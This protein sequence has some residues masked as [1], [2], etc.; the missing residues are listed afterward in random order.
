MFRLQSFVFP[1]LAIK[2]SEALYVRATPGTVPMLAD[3]KLRFTPGSAA[4]FDTFF[5]A[6]TV[7][8]WKTKCKIDELHFR[9]RGK[10]R[11]A[12]RFG[13][14]RRGFSQR[15]LADSEVSLVDGVDIRIELPF[16]AELEDGLLYVS[17]T[18]FEAGEIC[19]AAFATD[20][21]PV[22][23]VKLGIVITHFD[24]KQWVLPA[25]ERIR[26]NL[27]ADERYRGRIELVV[28]DNSRNIDPADAKGVTLIP[29][30]NL[31]GSGGF[32]RGLMHLEDEGSFTHCLFMDDD[33]SCEIESIRRAYALLSYAVEPKFAVAGS[34]LRAL[35]SHRLLEKG[36]RFD[37]IFQPL[38]SGLDMRR[39]DDLLLAER[40]DSHPSYGAWWFF[41]FSLTDVRHYPFPYFVRGDDITFGLM[42]KFSICTMNGIAT[43]SEDFGLKSGPLSLYLDVRSNIM[44]RMAIRD[45]GLPAIKTTAFNHFFYAQLRCYNYA[46]AAAISLAVEHI[47]QGPQFWRDNIDMGLVRAAIAAI[48]SEEKMTPI[49]RAD[50]AITYPRKRKWRWH[51]KLIRTFSLNGFLLP[52]RLIK[53]RM[54]FQRKSFQGNYREIFR[55]RKVLYEY[56]PLGLG[57][58][59]TYDKARFF[60]ELYV[61]FRRFLRLA[62]NYRDLQ[63]SYKKALPELTSRKFWEGVY[64]HEREVDIA[65]RQRRRSEGALSH[66]DGSLHDAGAPYNQPHAQQT[67][68]HGDESESHPRGAVRQP[69]TAVVMGRDHSF[70]Q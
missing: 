25:I 61:F 4:H 46:S 34:L 42:N 16:W 41:A 6:L 15:W 32:T 21:P 26:A 58:I 43:W 40:E 23:D 28:V 14:R 39:V 68:E 49:S 62:R 30:R 65:R 29:N 20:A 45:R 33:A 60:T 2:A 7:G 57:Y 8:T 70:D 19:A 31:G 53:T 55:N 10:G 35:E 5:N 17:V 12:V 3:G 52:N 63:K 67:D 27:L 69:Q 54:L 13:L 51:E 36:A 44:I 37:S 47:A 1:N 24:R 9:L 66:D 48:P 38:K 22:Q 11:F 59:A 18:A 56:E 50:Y 64:Q